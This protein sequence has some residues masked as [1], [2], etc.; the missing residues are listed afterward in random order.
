M[1]ESPVDL[2]HWRVT[3]IGKLPVVTSPEQSRTRRSAADAEKGTRMVY[4]REYGKHRKTKIYDGAKLVH[5]MSVE[6]PAVIEQETT[7]IVVLPKQSLKVNR[8]GDLI[9]S[10][11]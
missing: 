5:G 11:N 7:T 8:F 4:F 3:A 6:G 1:R 10:I 2:F 9:L